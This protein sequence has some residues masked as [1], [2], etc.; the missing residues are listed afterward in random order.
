MLP[1]RL[2]RH[3]A[4]PRWDAQNLHK[5]V[6]CC[7]VPAGSDSEEEPPED[8]MRMTFLG[9]KHSKPQQRGVLSSLQDDQPVSARM[10]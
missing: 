1:A 4:L 8:N 9:H 6:G 5:G 10:A 2:K 7:A 3:L